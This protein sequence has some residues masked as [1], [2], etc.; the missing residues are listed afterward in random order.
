M[1]PGACVER[2]LARPAGVLEIAGRSCDGAAR[3]HVLAIGKAALPMI[4]PV[5]DAARSEWARGL[6]VTPRSPEAREAPLLHR[7]LRVV[8][9]SHPIPDATSAAAGRAVREFTRSVPEEALLLVLLSG[10]AS[11]LLAEPL[12]GLSVEDGTAATGWLLASGL[13]I[14]AQNAVRKHLLA[15]GGGRLAAERPRGP[16]T[17]LAIS[18]V[19]D[20]DWSVIGS[21]PFAPDPSTFASALAEL[22]KTTVAGT[23]PKRARQFLEAGVRGEHPESPKPGAS[24]FGE[25]RSHLIARNRDAV[26]AVLAACRTEGVHSVGLVRP[27]RGEARE[28]GRRFA[29]LGNALAEARAPIVVCAGGE[30]T[31]TLGENSGRGGRNQELALAAALELDGHP[32]VAL[33]AAGSDGVDGPTDAA[34][35]VCDGGTCSAAREAGRDPSSHLRNHDAY[36]LFRSAGGLLQTGAT[37]TN[38]ADLILVG[39]DRA[40]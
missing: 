25:V 38:V 28:L 2:V 4:V 14:A 5:A 1:E 20:D 22:A 39:I 16:T 3:L 26:R 7:D 17:V 36:E 9:A 15:A 32:R 12:P 13:D 24:C 6:A 35:A 11:S 8:E 21:G 23:F 37:G 33:L 27:F 40:G 31:V 29:G 34:G 19:L 10:G 30:S 18:D